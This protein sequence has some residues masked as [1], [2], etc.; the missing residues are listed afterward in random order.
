[1]IVL[2]LKTIVS[3][4]S[5]LKP[6]MR[7]TEKPIN[8]GENPDRRILNEAFEPEACAAVIKHWIHQCHYWHTQCDPMIPMKPISRRLVQVCDDKTVRL[9]DT[10]TISGDYKY[11]T[12]SYCW[13]QSKSLCTT[14]SNIQK[15]MERIE[16]EDL[17]RGIQD[18]VRLA[19][20]LEIEYIWMDRFCIV[21]DD[22][23][24]WVTES[25]KMAY[26]YLHSSLTLS[27]VSA[28]D[29]NQGFLNK[30]RR[31]DVVTL[32]NLRTRS[33]TQPLGSS[34][35]ISIHSSEDQLSQSLGEILV[36]EI[37]PH[38]ILGMNYTEASRE[39][40]PLL[41]R[42]WCFQ[43]RLLST[44]TV[45]F[46]AQEMI[47]ECFR[48]TTCECQKLPFHIKSHQMDVYLKSNLK[49]AFATIGMLAMIPL[50][51]P[52]SLKMLWHLVV[53]IYSDKRITFEKDRLVALSALAQS[54][55]D[56][57]L[58]KY[59][60]GIW[61]NDIPQGLTWR[62]KG[63]KNRRAKEYKAPSWSW[64]TLEGPVTYIGA[65]KQS[66]GLAHRYEI[67]LKQPKAKVIS[68]HFE[69]ATINEFAD[70]KMGEITLRGL[71]T[72]ASI[73][74]NDLTTHKSGW[75]KSEWTVRSGDL[76]LG[77]IPDVPDELETV[78]G[79][80]IE[81]ITLYLG[82]STSAHIKALVLCK[83]P[84]NE[85][86][87]IRVGMMCGDENDYQDFVGLSVHD[88]KDSLWIKR[89]QDTFKEWFRKDKG[90]QHTD[91]TI[92]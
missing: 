57:K 41:D 89:M 58:G 22:N 16:F 83:S 92:I 52:T 54:L 64:A 2:A 81:C 18:S 43:E 71:V 70:A 35:V 61:E 72:P 5:M 10:S 74:W 20:A 31:L 55:D 49:L 15:F 1:L 47:W 11:M 42:A 75:M 77:M 51:T 45:H 37:L 19:K 26:I 39:D 68:C 13:G 32:E 24:D 91:I 73:L 4:I 69:P 30:R 53:E 23:E 46:T 78:Q 3:D 86:K 50:S 9:V 76:E 29:P 87:Y 62:S 28:K 82:E 44:R 67:P 12:L 59:M 84:T 21:Q 66:I 7:Y 79:S 65:A 6:L 8:T 63:S 33:V 85:T 14:T 80:A 60:A 27:L 36:R 40:L 17:P 38:D 88:Q 48:S 90:S 34:P 56:R 25:A